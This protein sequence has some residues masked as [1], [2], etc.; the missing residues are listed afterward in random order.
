MR[1]FRCN[2]I[3]FIWVVAFIFAFIQNIAFLIKFKA[4]A[5]LNFFTDVVFLIS[6]P[7]VLF[8][9][10]NIVF[11]IIA[12]PYIRKPIIVA[13]LLIGAPLNYFMTTYGTMVDS[14]M[15]RSFFET[16]SAEV[17]SLFTPQMVLWIVGFGVI[18]AV[19][20]ACVRITDIR[21]WRRLWILGTANA[22][23]S[24]LIVLSIATGLYKEY[25]VF[26]RNN[27]SIVKLITPI[28][29]M[30]GLAVYLSQRYAA[31][32]LP[33]QKIGLDAHREND[34]T[35][36]RKKTLF[37]L[38]I[39][40]AARAQNFSLNGYD[41][42]TT[43]QLA[44][45]A[46]VLSY[47]N[48]TSCGT[49]TAVSL[50]CMFSGFERKR[51][52]AVSAKR[53]DGLMDIVARAGYSVFWRENDNGCKG[54]CDRIPHEDT[55]VL[56][57]PQYCDSSECLDEILLWG[58][59]DYIAKLDRDTVIV[60][61]QIGSHGPTYY[62]RYSEA[63]RRYVPTCDTNQIQDCDAQSLLNTYDNSILYTDAQLNA[64]ISLLK[65]H[66]N[67]FS[68]AMVYLS[69]HGESLG[70]HGLYLHGT[71][72]AFAPE[73]QTHVPFITWLPEA[74]TEEWALDRKCL[75]DTA[76]D[77]AYS[78]DNLFHSVLG[79]LNIGTSEYKPELDMFKPCRQKVSDTA[80]VQ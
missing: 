54:V 10:L 14:A 68:T 53:R 69:D 60:L 77:G 65:R 26:F 7:V 43:P 31:A 52:D 62:K 63:F 42:E 12:Q 46:D 29:Y 36:G 56:K 75:S 30:N 61:H 2:N 34:Q 5:N 48:V 64:V 78:Q 18:P 19:W 41:R 8:C 72:Y 15:V 55:K 49:E 37:V 9:V 80:A 71:P 44:K 24:A 51:Y 20:V 25:A 32:E 57:L 66:Q 45:N 67:T 16:H 58:L 21:P 40:E 4:S 3:T 33:F 22:L 27:K 17:S 35:G 76:R 1:I 47:L 39:G 6:V 70:E 28:N 74:T 73:E 23:F 13:L 11:T 38:V 59:D 79:L 50:P